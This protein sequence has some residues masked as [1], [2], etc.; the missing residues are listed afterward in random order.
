MMKK[1]DI[2]KKET[3][4]LIDFFGNKLSDLPCI[5]VAG[6]GLSELTKSDYNEKLNEKILEA[7]KNVN[8]QS[9]PQNIRYW[10]LTLLDNLIRFDLDSYSIVSLAVAFVEDEKD[11]RNLMLAFKSLKEISQKFDMGNEVEVVFHSFFCYFPISF[12]PP[13]N[14]PYKI[15]SEDLKNA[16][17]DCILAS[18]K[19]GEFALPCLLDKMNSSNNNAKRDVLEIYS[20]CFQVY[21]FTILES[22]LMH[23]L[24]S[25]Q[26]EVGNEEIEASLLSCVRSISNTIPENLFHAFVSPLVAQSSSFLRNIDSPKANPTIKMMKALMSANCECFVFIFDQIFPI[27]MKCIE[28]AQDAAIHCQILKQ[29]FQICFFLYPDVTAC[30]LMERKKAVL[31][32]LLVLTLSATNGIHSISVLGYLLTIP[33][34]LDTGEISNVLDHLDN[35]AVLSGSEE[36]INWYSDACG[37]VIE[38]IC[39]HSVPRFMEAVLNGNQ[40]TE[41][42]LVACSNHEEPFFRICNSMLSSVERQYGLFFRVVRNYFDSSK[43]FNDGKILGLCQDIAALKLNNP[44]VMFRI[45]TMLISK[46]DP[47]SQATLLQ[48]TFSRNC[49]L[50][51]LR[52][53]AHCAVYCAC[54]AESIKDFSVL[55]EWICVSEIRNFA[56]YALASVLNK[57]D[58]LKLEEIENMSIN[59]RFLIARSYILK[60]DSFG[61]DIIERMFPLNEEN[62]MEIAEN[63]SLVNQSTEYYLS[64]KMHCNVNPIHKQF[65]LS[66]VLPLIIDIENKP[67]ELHTIYLVTLANVL[68]EA[69][70]QIV[71]PEIGRLLPTFIQAL[72]GEEVQVISPILNI[73]KSMIYN[74]FVVERHRELVFLLLRLAHSKFPIDIRMNSIECLESL[75]RAE[76]ALNY[77]KAV[78]NGLKMCLDDHKRKVRQKAVEC[79]NKWFLI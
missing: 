40:T 3:N 24:N 10:F 27:L 5:P 4:I 26:E 44:E 68:L 52:S 55:L 67:K 61:I 48:I 49:D 34:Y 76:N 1:I 14:D 74:P 59:E 60:L 30:P 38:R 18:P 56:V 15:T 32:T 72:E 41:K 69:P 78:L 73:L 75:C 9:Y 20:K 62:G 39:M 33:G 53:I 37:L 36:L 21:D 47:K 22:N 28:T 2:S 42:F 51:S 6:H 11:P 70:L 13:P 77:R 65:F 79:R 50:D 46:L 17:K 29:T 25:I 19:F 16:L 64:T 35:F 23:I 45:L 63:I 54:H 7:C 58:T 8:V 66:K 57:C 12:R 71:D 43:T 31:D